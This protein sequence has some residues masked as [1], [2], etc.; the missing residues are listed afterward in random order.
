VVHRNQE[1]ARACRGAGVCGGS[2]PG[3]DG[4]GALFGG[5]SYVMVNAAKR[6]YPKALLFARFRTRLALLQHGFAHSAALFHAC[7]GD[8]LF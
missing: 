6:I 8:A 4:C 3:A 1:L 7:A 2:W 5:L